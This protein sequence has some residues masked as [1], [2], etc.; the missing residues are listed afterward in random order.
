MKRGARGQGERFLAELEATFARVANGP[1][2]FPSGWTTLAISALCC[3]GSRT[4]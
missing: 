4:W 1:Q 3:L 2:Q